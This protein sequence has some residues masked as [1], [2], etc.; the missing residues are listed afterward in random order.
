MEPA[1]SALWDL[2]ERLVAELQQ[3]RQPLAE[4]I[5]ALRV[6]CEDAHRTEWERRARDTE[7]EDIRQQLRTAE[8]RLV[9]QQ[10]KLGD[11]LRERDGLAAQRPKWE[12]DLAHALSTLGSRVE[13]VRFAAG[14]RPEKLGVCT[15]ASKSVAG[16]ESCAATAV[17]QHMPF[18]RGDAGESYLKALRERLARERKDHAEAKRALERHLSIEEAEHEL[19]MGALSEQ[20]ARLQQRHGQVLEQANEAAGWHL[21]L[22]TEHETLKDRHATEVCQ[23]Q[24]VNEELARNL[25]DI[26][27]MQQAHTESAELRGRKLK[28]R[29]SKS[30]VPNLQRAWNDAAKV[31]GQVEEVR[32]LGSRQVQELERCLGGL[33]HRYQ[34]VVQ[35]RAVELSA[36]QKD[37]LALQRAT[38]QCEQLAVR[39]V[40]IGK[41]D[42]SD[43][44]HGPALKVE[45]LAL[46]PA[47]AKLRRILESCKVVLADECCSS[48][49][50]VHERT[51]GPDSEAQAQ[52]PQAQP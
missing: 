11:A 17:V 39:C 24:A 42:V 5:D 3:G 13:G 4:K 36:L 38:R 44:R 37:I 51:D 34:G 33:K 8:A 30:Q 7:A 21:R 6:P 19:L 23:L 52:L 49:T 2:F 16:A 50:R 20:N 22:S 18:S 46:R 26:A 41:A 32:D 29:A 48:P 31:R 27:L 14:A 9:A 1:A 10:R 40:G 35:H 12:A 47:V 45:A 28:D 43:G 25:H 15:Q